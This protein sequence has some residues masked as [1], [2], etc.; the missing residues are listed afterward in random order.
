MTRTDVVPVEFFKEDPDA[1]AMELKRMRELLEQ[2][3]PALRR[4]VLRLTRDE[5]LVS[6][7]M[8][9][10]YSRLRGRL[11][12]VEL[13][14]RAVMSRLVSLVNEDQQLTQVRFDQKRGSQ[15]ELVADR[16]SGRFL[17]DLFV[18]SEL[19]LFKECSSPWIAMVINLRLGPAADKSDKQIADMLGMRPYAFSK[20]W[21][22]GIEAAKEEYTRR[23]G[24]PV[25]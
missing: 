1:D 15:L 19:A 24:K 17:R 18:Q 7:Y 16:Q 10:L 22:R 2:M 20:R 13:D 5:S 25:P 12:Q 14:E 23:S 11:G 6:H 4:Q 9:R 8:D 3:F 21:N